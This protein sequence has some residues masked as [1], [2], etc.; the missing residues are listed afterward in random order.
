MTGGPDVLWE[1]VHASCPVR[2]EPHFDASVLSWQ[3]RGV[4]PES[5]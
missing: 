3:K 4:G 1:V 2:A 5:T